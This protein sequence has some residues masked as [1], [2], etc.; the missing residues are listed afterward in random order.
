MS[1]PDKRAP[2]GDGT[3]SETDTGPDKADLPEISR[4]RAAWEAGDWPTLARLAGPDQSGA[5]LEGAADRDRL[6]LF[7]AVGLAQT[8]DLTTARQLLALARRWG[9]PQ[10]VVAR[11]MLSGAF[12]TLGRVA[13]LM[14]DTDRAQDYAREA[15]V[16]AF[17][18]HPPEALAEIRALGETARLGL[19]PE[20]T[21]GLTDRL[22]QLEAGQLVS[23]SEASVFRTQLEL[24]NHML[25]IA[26]RRG[27]T[28]G[29]ESRATSQLGQDLWVLERTGMKRGGFFVE[30]GATDGVLLSNTYLL[31]SEFDWTGLCAEPNPAFFEKLS[32]NRSCT[33]SPDCI[34]AETGTEVEFIFADEYGGMVD[35][36]GA[37][38]HGARRAGFRERDGTA[39][40]TT[41][42]L[43]DFLRKH[44]APKTI[45][46]LSVDTEGSE[47][48]ILS[49]FPFGDWDVRLISVE[50]NFTP[51]RDKLRDL[52]EGHGYVR[53]EAQW[54]DWYERAPE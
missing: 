51:L 6:A 8:G 25:S 11:V 53:T 7:A 28:G 46:Y 34:G 36:A 43:D 47:Y 20:A 40:L 52:L 12:S 32:A 22:G 45:D 24:L 14:D 54:D 27:Q 4:A 9:C 37:D 3:E 42:S 30:F 31:E 44:D 19:L 16:T 50:H 35:H 2:G 23:T 49:A 48:D 41:I 38:A 5:A 18:D 29:L 1:D 26:Q 39:R 33:V 21:A 17:P 15:I 10:R 13:R